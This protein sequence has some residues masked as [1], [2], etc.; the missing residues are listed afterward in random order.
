M[1][2][3]L[4]LLVLLPL[5]ALADP[6]HLSERMGHDHYLAAWALLG[7]IAGSGWLVW[8]ELRRPKAPPAKR[9]AKDDEAG[10]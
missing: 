10:A 2:K 8:T 9:Q 6:G 3:I 4:P 1:R 7:V 5:P